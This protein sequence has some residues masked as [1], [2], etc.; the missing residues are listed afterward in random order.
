[1]FATP[2][3]DEIRKVNIAF[4]DQAKIG[5]RNCFRGLLA[6]SIITLQDEHYKPI[7][8]K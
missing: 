2:Q 8:A 6:Q 3:N 4:N 7:A 5:V 1:M